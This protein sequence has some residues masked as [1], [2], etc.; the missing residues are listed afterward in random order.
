[1]RKCNCLLNSS[2][3]ILRS[4]WDHLRSDHSP[5]FL[6]TV[7]KFGRNPFFKINF[8]FWKIIQRMLRLFPRFVL[9]YITRESLHQKIWLT[10]RPKVN[11]KDPLPFLS[12]RSLLNGLN[13]RFII[14]LSVIALRKSTIQK[15][16]SSRQKSMKPPLI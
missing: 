9:F 1:M 2:T 12:F 11:D 4:V 16:I 6:D 13:L 8:C 3:Y 5:I 7:F 14:P 15:S 10:N